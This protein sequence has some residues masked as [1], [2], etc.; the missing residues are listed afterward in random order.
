VRRRRKPLTRGLNKNHN[1]V[2]K[3]VFKSTATSA[4][5][6]PGPFQDLYR[7]MVARRGTCLTIG[8]SQSPKKRQAGSVM[9]SLR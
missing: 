5:G 6:R 1:R 2:L 7:G 3:D 4:I 8:P 9:P